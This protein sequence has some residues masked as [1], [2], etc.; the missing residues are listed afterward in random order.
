M[1]LSQSCVCKKNADNKKDMRCFL[2][3]F[4]LTGLFLLER[5]AC[6]SNKN[7]PVNEKKIRKHMEKQDEKSTFT[8]K[9]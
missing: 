8:Y 2:I 5:Q 7:S 1:K 9:I 4:S 6:L 3:F